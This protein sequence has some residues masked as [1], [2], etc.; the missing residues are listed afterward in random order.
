ML[1]EIGHTLKR[2]RSERGFTQ[3]ELAT[4]VSG[5]LDYTYIGKI[6]RGEQLPSLKILIALGEALGVPVGSFLGEGA[7][8]LSRSHVALA[9]GKERELAK[10]LR[11]LHPDDLPVLLDI[12]RALNRHR[13]HARKDRYAPAA[14][15]LP[16]AAEDGPSYGKP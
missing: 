8:P 12:V 14:D 1:H 16:L 9:G 13:K 5:G 11:Q 3:K 10:E 6:E 4:R 2:L 15:L 7:A